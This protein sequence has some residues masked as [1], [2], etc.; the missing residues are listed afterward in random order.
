M[1][2]LPDTLPDAQ[3]AI[4]DAV[5]A[6]RIP[7]QLLIAVEADKLQGAL[8]SA[9][10]GG[11]NY[12]IKRVVVTQP[13]TRTCRFHSDVP[14]FGGALRVELDNPQDIP[15]GQDAVKLVTLDT[16]RAGLQLLAEKYPFHAHNLLHDNGD[17][18]TGD[19]LLQVTIL[20]DLV[21]G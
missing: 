15:G 7:C 4:D 18:D 12:W 6:M 2:T 5:K 1:S 21:Y 10:E 3:D 16:L 17:A 8:I 20:G 14:F 13:P 11:S 19:A 9:F